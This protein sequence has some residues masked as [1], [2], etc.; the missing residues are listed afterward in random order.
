M[1]FFY[2]RVSTVAQNEGR[3]LDA[4]KRVGIADDK[5]FIDKESGKDFNRTNWK[6]L[7]KIIKKGD[8]LFVKSIDRIGR[9]YK[10]IIR[11]WQELTKDREVDVVVLDMP[12]LD[13]RKEKNLLGTFV[14]DIVLQILSFVAENERVNILERQRQGIEAAKARGVKFGRPKIEIPEDFETTAR[15]YLNG[16]IH[17]KEAARRLGVKNTWFVSHALRLGKKKKNYRAAVPERLL[18][19]GVDGDKFDFHAKKW[20]DGEMNARD[21]AAALGLNITTFSKYAHK[22]F[23]GRKSL[24]RAKG[25]RIVPDER[26]KKVALSWLEG[27]TTAKIAAHN[28]GIGVNR[29]TRLARLTFPDVQRI[30]SGYFTARNPPNFEEIVNDWINGNLSQKEAARR[31]GY[32]RSTFSKR[33]KEFY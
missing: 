29:F 27:K 9:N 4:A 5:I 7:T 28:C 15:L 2:A 8:V 11:V 24:Y 25:A 16:E 19:K 21:A 31:C 18:P 14:A 32:S 17:H 12:L 3:Q 1:N 22:R 30:K 6:L 26:F 33:A 10:E 23:P 20:F 13:T